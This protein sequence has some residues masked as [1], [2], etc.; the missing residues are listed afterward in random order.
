MENNLSKL[1]FSVAMAVFGTIGLFVRFIPFP[2]SVISMCRG[3][4]GAAFLIIFIVAS[5]RD[6]SF[7]AIKNNLLCLVLSGIA[8]G[9]NWVLLF[10]SYKYTSV[11]KATLCYYMAPF[12][13]MVISPFVFKENLTLKK[14]ICI[15][16]SL[17]GM[18]LVSGVLEEKRLSASEAKGIVLGLSSAVLY[19]VIIVLNKRLK[20][21]GAFEK[22]AVQLL[23]CGAVTLG[24]SLV[25]GNISDT[26]FTV[27]GIILMFT[28]CV[29]HT[30]IAYLLYF[31]SM[32]K[33]RAQSIAILSYIDPVVAVILSSFIEKP[34]SPLGIIGA[35]LIVGSAI[36]A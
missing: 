4:L 5:H 12:M 2:S 33:L 3:F 22:T 6:F 27:T 31:G 14:C 8:I 24:Y 18:L 25:S 26:R 34:M 9:F 15:V 1:K 35:V 19:A 23:S 29:V 36:V 17:F 13:I 28:V 10:E 7:K 32:D 21:I 30:G 11:A 16:A 20:D